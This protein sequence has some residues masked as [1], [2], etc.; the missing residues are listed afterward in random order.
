[1][2]SFG[3]ILLQIVLLKE[4]IHILNKIENEQYNEIILN[5]LYENI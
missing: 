3:I 2:F 4:E 5:E 1:M